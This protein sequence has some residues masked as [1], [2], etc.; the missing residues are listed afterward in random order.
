MQARLNTSSSKATALYAVAFALL[1]QSLFPSGYMPSSM[2]S[3]W[4][5]ML[6]PE[7]LPAAFVKQLGDQGRHGAHHMGADHAG[8]SEHDKGHEKD[9][10]SAGYCELGSGLDQPLDL[11]E[12]LS[13]DAVVLET[14]Q[15][16]TLPE[17]LRTPHRPFA[18][19]TESGLLK[20]PLVLRNRP[21]RFAP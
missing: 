17:V 2:A 4:I 13:F 14:P 16:M 11:I 19:L 3:G 15:L 7:G 1:V 12:N 8:S 10:G 9:H 6:C 18:R 21:A 20:Q 5:A